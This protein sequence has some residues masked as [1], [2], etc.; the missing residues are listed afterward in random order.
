MRHRPLPQAR[1]AL[2]VLSIL[3]ALVAVGIATAVYAQ[4]SGPRTYSTKGKVTAVQGSKLVIKDKFGVDWEYTLPK[5]ITAA[6]GKEV[7]VVYVMQAVK[8]ESP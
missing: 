6:V 2:S 7:K 4:G 5:G 1:V 8:I 3:S